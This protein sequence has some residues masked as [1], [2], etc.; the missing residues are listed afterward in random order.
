MRD[1]I[2]LHE[3]AV[4]GKRMLED[5][6]INCTLTSY[7]DGGHFVSDQDMEAVAN[8]LMQQFAKI[9]YFYES[10][11]MLRYVCWLNNFLDVM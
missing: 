2:V 10:L 5:L 1:E 9:F 7:E 6:S 3:N 8:W 11:E 4:K